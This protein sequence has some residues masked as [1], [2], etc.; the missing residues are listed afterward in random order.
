MPVID[1]DTHVDESESTWEALDGGPYEKYM[2][3]TVTIE[4]REASRRDPDRARLRHWLVEDRLQNRA[5]RDDRHH[6][7][8]ASRELEDVAGRL[9]QMDEMGVDV[10]VVFPTFFIRYNTGNPEAER[11]LTTTYN[12]WLAEKCDGTNGRLRWAA[13][14]PWLQPSEAVRELRWAKEH[15]ACGIFKRGF[16]LG[17]PTNDPCFLPV[18]EAAAALDLPICVHTGHPG[19]D[20]GG[21]RGVPIMAAF[22]ALVSGGIAKRFPRLRFG[23]IEAGASWV[24]YSIA[25]LQAQERTALDRGTRTRP[26]PGLDLAKDLFRANRMFVTV[27][28]VDD[29][30]Y[31]LG[32]GLED[33]LMIG[34]DYSHSDISANAGALERVREWAREGRI[35]E[36]VAHKI[37]EDNPAAFYGL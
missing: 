30:E 12:R 18:Y 37:L 15:G 33:N 20:P 11:A 24:P 13:V 4:P 17:R 32:F 28:A 36:A 14:L 2:P 10:Q 29:I 16:E 1:A 7:P 6:P 21:D 26:A 9:R 31:L 25:Q 3:A 22:T 27:D 34:T 35:S 8:R 19:S 5:I 23:L